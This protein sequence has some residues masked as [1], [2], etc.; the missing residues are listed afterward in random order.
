MSHPHRLLLKWARLIHVYLTLFGFLIL[1][2]FGVTGF[3]LNHPDMFGYNQKHETVVTG[4]MPTG[5]LQ[6]PVKNNLAI[7]ELLRKDYGAK[8]AMT[9]FE[10]DELDRPID[11]RFKCPG[12]EAEAKIQRE[13]GQ[14]TVTH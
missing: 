3:M 11:V 8:G 1:L 13:D 7:V 2:F 6:E 5:F 14:T 12:R 9:T 4:I 10:A